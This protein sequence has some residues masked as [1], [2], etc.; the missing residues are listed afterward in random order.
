M[1]K[2]EQIKEMGSIELEQ[3]KKK[4]KIKLLTIIGVVFLYLPHINNN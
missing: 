2:N 1:E 4:H 3:N